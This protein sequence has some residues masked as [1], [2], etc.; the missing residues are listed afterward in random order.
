M[1]TP[2]L[3]G[4]EADSAGDLTAAEILKG[5]L[6]GYPTDTYALNG[7]QDLDWLQREHPD[8]PI[9]LVANG[10][11]SGVTA[12]RCDGQ[13]SLMSL[14]APALPEPEARLR[15]DR[16][17]APM[18]T[19]VVNRACGP[20]PVTCV[21]SSGWPDYSSGSSSQLPGLRRRVGGGPVGAPAAA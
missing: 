9:Q 13:G 19:T 2:L 10:R 1:K 3:S 18:G 12:H 5:Q 8:W 16:S 11:G 6:A 17:A 20:G 15:G 7:N 21:L 4:P 14:F